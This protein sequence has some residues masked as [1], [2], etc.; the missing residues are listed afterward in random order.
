MTRTIGSMV[1][2]SDEEEQ[3]AMQRVQEARIKKESKLEKKSK[4]PFLKPLHFIPF[5]G[6]AEYG[7]DWDSGLIQGNSFMYNYGLPLMHL[8]EIVAGAV[9]ALYGLSQLLG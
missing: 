5:K 8:T 2:L 3:E 7:R 9:G 1:V 6:H 4:I